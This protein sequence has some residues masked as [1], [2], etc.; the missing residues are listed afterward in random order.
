MGDKCIVCEEQYNKTELR[1]NMC[2]DCFA[3]YETLDLEDK[4]FHVYNRV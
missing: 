4:F 1:Y 2:E 3:D